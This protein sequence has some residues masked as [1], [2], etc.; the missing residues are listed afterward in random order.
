MQPH[1]ALLPIVLFCA[2]RGVCF[3]ADVAEPSAPFR[4]WEYIVIHH[5]ATLVGSADVFDTAHRARGMTHGL[6]YHFV[7][8]NGT[9]GT[10]DGCVEIGDRWFQQLPGGHCKQETTNERAIGICLVGDF[11]EH[12]P[13]AQQMEAL[14]QLVRALQD[15]FQIEDDY[16]VGHGELSG[17]ST[18]CPGDRFSWDTLWARLHTG[19]TLTASSAAPP[20]PTP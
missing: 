12:E 8:D 6:A 9:R 18:E 17:E 1:K 11:S 4:A 3:A 2:S 10:T 14:I 13:T 5:S 16:I 20:N 15:R 7:I 19:P